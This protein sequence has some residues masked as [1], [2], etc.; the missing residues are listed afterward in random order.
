GKALTTPERLVEGLRS[1]IEAAAAEI[2]L[3]LGE[4]LREAGLFVYAT[5]QATNAVIEGKTART[6]LLC[7]AGFPDVLVRR[8]GGSMHPYDFARPVP[9]PYIPRRLTF[10]I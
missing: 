4:A 1:G 5:T 10:E 2:G 9:E 7:T 6:A 8:E 3:G